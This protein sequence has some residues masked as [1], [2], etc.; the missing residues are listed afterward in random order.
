MSTTDVVII[1]AGPNGLSISA[2]L[3]R[4]GIEHRVFGRTMETWRANMP[5]GMMLKSEPYASDLSAPEA[6][7]GAGDYC[8]TTHQEYHERLTP[9]SRERFISYGDWFADQLVP[10]VEDVRVHSLSTTSEGFRIETSDDE[11]VTARRVVVATGIIPFAYLPSVFK[12]APPE[13]VSHTSWHSDLSRFSGKEVVVVGGGQSALESAA[14]LREQG[15]SVKVVLRG[16]KVFW[17]TPN[18]ATVSLTQN[19]RR[20]VARLCEGWPCWAFDHLPDVFTLMPKSWRVEH[21]LGF[22]GPSGSWWLRER[23]ESHIPIW[24]RHK[25]LD[26]STN[27]DRV[28]L[29]LD[30]PDGRLAVEADHVVAGTGFRLDLARLGF[31]EDSLVSQLD[32][33]AGAPKLTRHLESKVSGLFFTGAPAAPSLGPLMRFVAGTHFT[34]PRVSRRIRSSLRGVGL[35]SKS[36]RSMVEERSNVA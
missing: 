33:V 4:M 14:L 18:P 1:G 24:A 9:L 13:L 32:P 11:C 30:G 16:E 31:L 8:A 12:D 34:G 36:R 7:F 6:G 15:A 25:V 29:Q 20:P 35:R 28:L 19:I 10:N 21:G 22:L 2:H 3:G 26:A 5:V 17:N 27:G 23:V